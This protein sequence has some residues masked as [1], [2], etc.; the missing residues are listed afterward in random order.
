MKDGKSTDHR[1]V[2]AV[3][4]LKYNTI[5]GD[6][7]VGTVL[8]EMRHRHWRICGPTVRGYRTEYYNEG[9][10]DLHSSPN[11]IRVM[12]SSMLR[13]NGH[14]ERMGKKRHALW[15]EREPEE[16]RLFGKPISRWK[17]NTKTDRKEI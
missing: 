16:G 1:E 15:M 11:I 6:Y 12:K 3:L 14:V 9:N 2:V 13:M 5:I 17:G 8:F 10:H 4:S 7:V